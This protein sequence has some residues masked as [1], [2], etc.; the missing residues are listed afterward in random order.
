MNENT[1]R[2]PLRE[3]E[4]CHAHSPEQLL[5]LH[6]DTLL[7]LLVPTQQGRELSVDGYKLLSDRHTTHPLPPDATPEK[8][9]QPDTLDLYEPRLSYIRRLLH[10]LQCLVELEADGQPV[11]ID[12]FRLRNPNQWLAPGGGADDILAHAA[13]RCN[14]S[15]RFCYNHGAPAT[16]EQAPRPPDLEFD[17]IRTRIEHYVP[18]GRL[19]LFPTI[20]S[21]C[22]MLAH[23][24][25]L[26]I[27]TLLREKTSETFRIP[28]NGAALTPDMVRSL[29]RLAPVYVDVSL[30]SSSPERRRWLM[31]DPSPI[32]AIQSL[33]LLREEKIPFTV[34]IVPWPFPSH[35]AMLD[36]LEATTTFAAAFDPALIQ[37]SLPGYSRAT[38]QD[39]WFP[40]KEVWNRLRSACQRIRDRI[41]CPLIMRPGL[42]EEYETPGSCNDPSVLGL[43]KNSP[44]AHAGL[45]QG[46]RIKKVNRLPVQSRPQARA[47]LNT[48]H[49]SDLNTC[50]LSIE[51]DGTTHEMKLDLSHFDYPYTP[52]TATHLG[53]VFASSG[54][55]RE[56]AERV[57]DV[58][59]TR[60]A[61][62]TL[63]MTSTLVRPTLEKLVRESGVPSGTRLHLC[64]PRN[65]FFGGNIF[66]GDL[67]VVEDFITAAQ[68]FVKEQKIR[69]DL[70]LIPSSPFRISGWGRDLTGRP[71]L[72]IERS[73]K[74]PVALIECDT[75]FD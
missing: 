29:A 18:S 53:V 48:L 14:L 27:L 45:H 4:G 52:E 64:V 54:I 28:T 61:K 19:N 33:A 42:F 16:L 17:E 49:H 10:S 30:N 13:T 62:E 74:I 8:R 63:L 75:I 57:R 35:Q 68:G 47:L 70:I 32:T 69:P 7:N 44:A 46:D 1:L 6:L 22:E 26:D 71:Y 31:N 73:L 37:V 2:F 58:I 20:G 55:P 66:M 24:H 38:P 12:G 43:V 59:A 51:R 21:P 40:A 23:P 65:E 34:V 72:D 9:E 15:C 36:D 25:I 3:H 39:E 41:P 56:W 11:R 50:S 60:H 67:M 5:G